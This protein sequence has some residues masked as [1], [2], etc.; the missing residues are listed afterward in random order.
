LS[1]NGVQLG[2]GAFIL[3]MVVVFYLFERP[4]D[5]TW[6]FTMLPLGLS[7]YGAVPRLP[8]WLNESL[9]AFLHASSLTLATG[10][11]LGPRVWEYV[12]VSV[13]WLLIHIIF[14]LGQ[15]LDRRLVELAPV[16]VDRIPLVNHVRSHFGLGTFDAADILAAFLGCACGFGIL[17]LTRSREAQI[18]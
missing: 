10:S 17:M 13:S 14:E 5:G 16:W 3:S 2:I 8:P 6:L 4:L 18:P 11:L 1:A 15:R 7:G 12:W 9:P